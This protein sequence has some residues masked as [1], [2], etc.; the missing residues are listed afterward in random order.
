[1]QR[2]AATGRV[3]ARS[4]RA[5]TVR[6]QAKTVKSPGDPRVVRGTCFVTR[7]VRVDQQ[8]QQQQL[9]ACG[10]LIASPRCTADQTEFPACRTLIQTRSSQLST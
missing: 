1:M 10:W 4:S 6:V 5:L 2:S 9:P 8:Q 3:A 7:D